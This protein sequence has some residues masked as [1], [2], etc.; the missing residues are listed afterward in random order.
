MMAEQVTAEKIC[1][2]QKNS[3]DI[4]MEGLRG[5]KKLFRSWGALDLES[6]NG[7]QFISE[8]NHGLCVGKNRW[9]AFCNR[10][11]FLDTLKY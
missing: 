7:V 5:A 4:K 9:L 11:D 3:S 10:E 2:D 8:I 1:C 6:R